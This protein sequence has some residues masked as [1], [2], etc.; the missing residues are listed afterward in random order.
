MS[1]EIRRI[2]SCYSFAAKDA[3][4]LN[5]DND[6]FRV[7]D[8]RGNRYFLKIYG[9]DNDYDIIP[10]ERIY[11]TYEQVRIESEILNLLSTGGMKTAVPVS[12]KKGEF[13]TALAPGVNG[14]PSP[15]AMVTSFIEA[16]PMTLTAETA[17][18]AGVTAARLHLE[19][20]R[21][22]LSL[23]VKR[24]HKRKDYVLKMR[25]RLAQGVTA[26]VFTGAQFE[27]ISQCCGV[28][29][30]CMN[31]L[32][33]DPE[34]NVGLVHTDIIPG[35]CMCTPERVIPVDFSRCVY[36]Y[37]LYDLGE[38]CFHSDF[39][40]SSPDLRNAVLR[41]YHS[42][43]PLKKEHLF[44]IQAFFFMFLMTVLAVGIDA[45]QSA[46]R[47]GLLKWLAAEVHPGL[48][49]GRGWSDAAY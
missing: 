12:N 26:N 42:V 4:S 48:I 34:H 5:N 9:N 38:M 10:G 30:D 11:H 36:S 23:A 7:T 22:L 37:Y 20:E 18:L 32:D 15:Y 47:D 39:G 14:G 27:M 17:Y 41:G 31:R 1:D 35:N 28:V 3:H 44:M 29:L 2:L 45:G 8:D 40:G 16:P 6:V 25:N 13:V 24:P 46:W 33:E 21:K 43:K 19:S 49:S